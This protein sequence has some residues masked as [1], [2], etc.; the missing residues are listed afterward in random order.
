MAESD[1]LRK[2]IVFN[3]IFIILNCLYY[4]VKEFYLQGET[5]HY[6]KQLITG[7]T[8]INNGVEKRSKRGFSDR[9]WLTESTLVETT[10]QQIEVKPGLLTHTADPLC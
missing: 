2:I 7:S 6:I 8:F 10:T 5:V 1:K 9:S 4:N 3:V